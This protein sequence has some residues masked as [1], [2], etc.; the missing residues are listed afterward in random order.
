RG[1]ESRLPGMTKDAWQAQLNKMKSIG[2]L[3]PTIVTQVNTTGIMVL[4]RSGEE[5]PINWDSMKWAR[6]FLNTNSL[7]PRPQRPSDV[8][9]VGDVVRS[10]RDDQGQLH[11]SQLPAAQSALVSLDPQNGAIRALVGGF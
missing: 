7:G 11:F 3:E 9:A 4:S 2:G 1:P 10:K 5:E 6:P 8:V